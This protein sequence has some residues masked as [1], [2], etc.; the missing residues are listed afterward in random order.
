MPKVEYGHDKNKL[1][2]LKK[3]LEYLKVERMNSFIDNDTTK[4]DFY[5]GCIKDTLSKIEELEK[6]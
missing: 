6:N 3:E 2:E 1:E 5:T 4:V